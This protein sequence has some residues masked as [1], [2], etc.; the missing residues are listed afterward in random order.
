MDIFR[1]TTD[2]GIEYSQS[3]ITNDAGTLAPGETETYTAT[4]TITQEHI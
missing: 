4:Y 3:T 1:G 2:S